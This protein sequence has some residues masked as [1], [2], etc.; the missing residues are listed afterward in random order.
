MTTYILRR[1]I[2]GLLVMLG[3][4]FICFVIFRFTGRPGHH[5]CRPGRNPR[6]SGGGAAGLRPRQA[7]L[8]PVPAL[9]LACRSVRVRPL[10]YIESSGLEPHPRTPAG[11]SGACADGGL[12]RFKLRDLPRGCRFDPA[13]EPAEPSHYDGVLGRDLD[14][15]LFDRDNFD[16]GLCGRVRGPAAIR[17]RRYRAYRQLLGDE[18][19]DS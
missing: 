19:F 9:A 4:T 8:R 2:Q 15:D 11:H 16:H 17:P 14:P 18:L 5:H 6:P 1:V 7:L 3:V 12:S 13:A 10:I